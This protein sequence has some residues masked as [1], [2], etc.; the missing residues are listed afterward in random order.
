MGV[1]HPNVLINFNWLHPTV[2]WELDVAS[3]EEAY[4]K[5]YK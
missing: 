5:S 3:L 1:V 2:M 4:T